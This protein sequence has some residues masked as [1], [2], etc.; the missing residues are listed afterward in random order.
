[1]IIPASRMGRM[2]MHRRTY[3]VAV[4]A[5]FDFKRATV[6]L[7]VPSVPEAGAPACFLAGRVQPL[8]SPAPDNTPT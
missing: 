5:G 3:T 1:M 6:E 7:S 4:D 8:A 2:P